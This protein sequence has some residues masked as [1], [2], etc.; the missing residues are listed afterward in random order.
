MTDLSI[1]I[2]TAGVVFCVAFCALANSSS[3]MRYYLIERAR[4]R[5]EVDKV[6]EET[7]AKLYDEVKRS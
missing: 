6:K 5:A 4:L 3:D 7:K 1:G 2:L